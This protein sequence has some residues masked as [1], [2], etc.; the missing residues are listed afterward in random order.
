[1]DSINFLLLCNLKY[2]T[3]K[4]FNQTYRI[5]KKKFDPD[6]VRNM[7][8]RIGHPTIVGKTKTNHPYKYRVI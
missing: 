3:K 1:M 2:G 7:L 6:F 4:K 5:E 8:Q